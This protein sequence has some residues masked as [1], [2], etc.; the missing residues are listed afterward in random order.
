[1]SLKGR[2][3]LVTGASRGIGAAAARELARRGAAVAVNYANNA[4]AAAAVVRDIEAA[5]GKAVAIQADVR[6]AAQVEALF[7]R[8]EAALGPVDTLV[9]N[10][11]MSFPMAPFT[12]MPWEG[13]QQKLLGELAS[14]FHPCKAAVP[15]MI[16]RGGGCIVAVSSG[17]SRHPGEGFAAHTTA[18][19]GLDG[20]AKALALEL[21]PHGI[22]VNVVAPGLTE[23]DATRFM[24]GDLKA[25]AARHVPLRRNGTPEDIA[26]IIAAVVS[27]GCGYLTG[28][29]IPA[30]GGG[31]ML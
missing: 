26:G 6:D 22:R 17:L 21:G 24:P 3:A 9:L 15:G 13:F 23:T 1:M 4:E 5:G 20:F 2:I 16:R 12:E 18:K 25:M 11:N 10:A 14:A 19:S 27:D 29:Y 30:G 7:A 28:A 31:L 8:A